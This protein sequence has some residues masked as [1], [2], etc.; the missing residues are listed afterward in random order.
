VWPSSLIQAWD[1]Y[2][3]SAASARVN[4]FL[5]QTILKEDTGGGNE[6]VAKNI[7]KVQKRQ[8]TKRGYQKRA[9]TTGHIGRQN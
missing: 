2:C 1:W 8:D 4:S 9:G 7:G 5:A 3:Q 6:L